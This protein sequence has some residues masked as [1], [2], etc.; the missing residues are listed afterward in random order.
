[1]RKILWAL[2]VAVFLGGV[3]V[4]VEAAS[5]TPASCKRPKK[6]KLIKPGKYKAS[7]FKFRK[8]GK[9]RKY[10]VKPSV[11]ASPKPFSRPAPDPVPGKASE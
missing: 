9:R 11:A 8:V 3:A 7:K 1:V 5:P 4:P 6:A 10:G 2:V